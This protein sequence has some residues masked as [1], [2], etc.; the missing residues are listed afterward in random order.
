MLAHEVVFVEH[1]VVGAQEGVLAAHD[2]YMERL[3]T[4]FRV[5]VIP[6]LHFVVA[7]ETGGRRLPVVWWSV[8]VVRIVGALIYGPKRCEGTRNSVSILHFRT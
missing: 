4:S 3:T 1:S 8:T 6:T 2:A 7:G 5:G